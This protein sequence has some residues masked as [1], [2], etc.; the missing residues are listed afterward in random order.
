MIHT[1]RVYL[2]IGEENV[3]TF[4]DEMCHDKVK[5]S[6]LRDSLDIT[7]FETE[8][9]EEAFRLGICKINGKNSHDFCEITEDNFRKLKKR[10]K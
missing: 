8:A 1:R 6:N 10:L 4:F 2:I 3:D 9:E 7:E 5:L